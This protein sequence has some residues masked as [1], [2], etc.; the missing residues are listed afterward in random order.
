[1]KWFRQIALLMALS[2]LAACMGQAPLSGGSAPAPTAEAFK[3]SP[4]D[5]LK[6]VTYGE[7]SLSGDFEV[8]PAGTIVF[9]LI[10]EVKAAGLQSEELTRAIEAKLADG[11]LLEPKVSAQVTSFRPIYV[12]GE[13][14]KPGEYPYTQ[15]LTIRGAVAKADGFTYRANEK[16]VFLK[17]AGETG[18]KV[19][20]L[21]AD[22]PVL[23]GDTIRFA[24]R[25]F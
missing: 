2:V 22:F 10:G 23:P 21:T 19:Y 7:Q 16:K 12:L 4:G 9:P 3:L 24:E 6:I 8:S 18:E 17:R 20:P 11:F 25:Y 5:K 1:M 13:V 14:R 15:G